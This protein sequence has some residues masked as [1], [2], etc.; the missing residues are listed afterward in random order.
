MPA[1]WRNGPQSD[2]RHLNTLIF[3]SVRQS[4][5]PSVRIVYLLGLYEWNCRIL[6]A[7]LS[8]LEKY[9]VNHSLFL[10]TNPSM[11]P[12]TDRRTL[13]KIFMPLFN[14]EST[15]AIHFTLVSLRHLSPQYTF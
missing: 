7:S 15:S 4:I 5:H 9:L 10:S 3:M 11:H 12:F 8:H 14:P 2:I 6:Y 1:S 13:K